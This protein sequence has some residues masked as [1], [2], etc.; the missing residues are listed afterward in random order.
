MY[1]TSVPELDFSTVGLRLVAADK[2]IA[3][4]CISYLGRAEV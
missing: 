2:Q 3:A 4:F 1:G